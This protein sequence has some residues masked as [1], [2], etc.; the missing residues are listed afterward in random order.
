MGTI[1]KYQDALIPARDGVRILRQLAESSP[2]PDAR[3]FL[4]IAL[5]NLGRRHAKLEQTQAA[6]EVFQ[7]GLSILR[8]LL[9]SRA[10]NRDLELLR[11]TLKELSVVL[12]QLGKT[13]DLLAE[14]QATL[15]I[16]SL[17]AKTQPMFQ[18]AVADIQV[19]LGD[20][21]SKLGRFSEAQSSHREALE[22]LRDQAIGRGDRRFVLK[23]TLNKLMLVNI[24]LGQL[25]SLKSIWSEML[26]I[27]ESELL[28]A[29]K[30]ESRDLPS[31]QILAL[32]LMELMIVHNQL[33]QSV[34]S[35]HAAE[36]AMPLIREI[37]KADPANK[38]WQSQQVD[39]LKIIASSYLESGH[40]QKIVAIS[41]E[42]FPLLR[43][44]AKTDPSKREELVFFLVSLGKLYGLGLDT[45]LQFKPYFQEAL[46]MISSDLPS[47]RQQAGT[48]PVAAGRVPS[49]GVKPE[50]R[51]P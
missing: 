49:R 39:V 7:E 3:Y 18:D 4:T 36:E 13:Q 42:L 8:I 47:L 34:Q 11:E 40:T 45:N 12:P 17:A 19:S 51:M 1:G 22:I 41:E 31:R 6:A 2:E 29:R 26:P 5:N 32:S 48:R 14:Q 16:L 10:N 35:L 28:E 23:T 44:V 20:T 37:I 9:G 25:D 30:N 21:Y 43:E 46:T 24:E 33:G 50:A 15:S 27:V 38:W